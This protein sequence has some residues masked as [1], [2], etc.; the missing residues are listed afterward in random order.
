MP[1]AGRS[2]IGPSR[3]PADESFHL[4]IPVFTKC[5]EVLESGR[6]LENLSWRL[7]FREAHLMPPDMTLSDLAASPTPLSLDNSPM[8]TPLNRSR[9]GSFAALQQ[10][11]H[12]FAAQQQAQA[13]QSSGAAAAE[14]GLPQSFGA[15]SA[16]LASA[17]AASAAGTTPS[18]TP[19]ASLSAARSPHALGTSVR[20]R[21][22]ILQE[23][24]LENPESAESESSADE[25]DFVEEED[26]ER[27]EDENAAGPSKP[28]RRS[29]AASNSKR[30]SAP[31]PPTSSTPLSR[32]SSTRVSPS[33]S[34]RGTSHQDDANAPPSSYRQVPAGSSSA[35]AAVTGGTSP[36]RHRR[37]GASTLS[38]SSAFGS[39]ARVKQ[40]N[41]S[42]Y[43]MA[44]S[45]RN[46]GPGSLLSGNGSATSPSSSA[47]TA[48]TSYAAPNAAAMALALERKRRRPVSFQ[49]AVESMHLLSSPTVASSGDEGSSA[50]SAGSGAAHDAHGHATGAL[51]TREA[52]LRDLSMPIRLPQPRA[53]SLDAA[54][55]HA[56]NNGNGDAEVPAPT[57]GSSYD[58]TKAS[59][60]MAKARPQITTN[61][62]ADAVVQT[63][64]A[65]TSP[66]K[67][68]A[69]A[70]RLA[71]AA[72]P[73]QAI[74]VASSPARAGAISPEPSGY[75]T[76]TPSSPVEQPV[77]DKR[78]SKFFV[79]S[80]IS[81]DE[82]NVGKAAAGAQKEAKQEEEQEAKPAADHGKQKEKSH[83]ATEEHQ[84]KPSLRPA[85]SHGKTK[86]NSHTKAHRPHAHFA[87]TA[88]H[89]A[90][91]P[92][93]SKSHTALHRAGPNKLSHKGLAQLAHH[94]AAVPHRRE[95]ESVSTTSASS[96]V[97]DLSEAAA[98]QEKAAAQAQVPAV[99]EAEK[100]VEQAPAAEL[101]KAEEEMAKRRP[102]TF[103][104]GGDSDD[105]SQSSRS[106]SQRSAAGS[107]PKASA[108]QEQ[109]E[110]TA[111]DEN[112]A[113]G[114]DDDEW[115]SDESE[116]EVL[117]A[118]Q[119]ARLQRQKREEELFKK[120]P[121]RSKSAA[122]V[123]MLPSQQV[124]ATPGPSP[125]QQPVRGL[126]SS[127]FHPESEPHPP[128]GQ[129]A[130]R[131]HAS[132]ADLRRMPFSSLQMSR[133][134]APVQEQP[135]ARKEQRAPSTGSQDGERERT[136]AQLSRS[137]S[138]IRLAGLIGNDG[139]SGGG[140]GLR[141]SKSAVALP[142]LNMTASRSTTSMAQAASQ[143]EMGRS[144]RQ[145][146]ATAALAHSQRSDS[147]QSSS[148]ATEA[149]GSFSYASSQRSSRRDSAALARLSE[150]T[151]GHQQRAAA[152]RSASEAARSYPRTELALEPPTSA[153][154]LDDY[155]SLKLVTVPQPDADAED[156]DDTAGDKSGR[157]WNGTSTPGHTQSRS[158]DDA[159]SAAATPRQVEH[160]LSVPMAM[161]LPEG[162]APQTPRT[163]RRNMLRDELSESLRQN[164]LW[165]RQSR[166]RMLGIVG[167]PMQQA[168][169][170]AQQQQQHQ[171]AH[172]QHHPQQA[173][174]T[175]HSLR[176]DTVLGGG[177]IRPLTSARLPSAF[178]S[179]GQ[180]SREGSSQG[181]DSN[182]DGAQHGGVRRTKSEWGG[183]FHHTGW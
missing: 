85:L 53:R 176:K 136:A 20:S 138:G 13:Q 65:S 171:Q 84:N 45:T 74:D 25:N 137:R 151:S 170:A 158:A 71:V 6:R 16:A 180:M 33:H 9:A 41:Q 131:P 49:A 146:T 54:G 50:A 32:K 69:A 123:R 40:R 113:A 107:V 11:L 90:H 142:L 52:V 24:G 99:K 174:P 114:D 177:A 3:P 103:T 116:E 182:G 59:S 141:T 18:R 160:R 26:E 8:P 17:A 75:K 100:P 30:S 105:E 55:R 153:A 64:S 62:S 110:A 155:N 163:T 104:M 143:A 125:P 60:T 135:P 102:V 78:P 150:L 106:A 120:V 132:A 31:A 29:S 122:D 166:N 48:T 70:E 157:R 86:H 39:R 168:N 108:Q 81:D 145:P 36:S 14:N 101:K 178:A 96:S 127:I 139:G 66:V 89:H 67:V 175:A 111:G 118:A 172:E 133:P 94:A 58:E 51:S 7:W 144:S 5:A 63:A 10:S 15:A 28:R 77:G 21:E 148:G 87:H 34:R 181:A 179:T 134:P 129:L 93:R 164:L 91:L 23:E 35:A 68:E 38:S 98:K 4:F 169:A 167:G 140:A 156:G 37:S 124:D 42:L 73:T 61:R 1:T 159:G 72:Q 117:T 154:A 2:S 92:G 173:P 88:S 97:V 183:S 162:G 12:Q 112:A 22:A 115:S 57:G 19:F 27:E 149:S 121:I 165:E 130:G 46:A 56:E 128:P 147:G 47:S 83:A 161:D 126:L 109:K 76:V 82:D 43:A 95:T 119:L 80:Y 44:Q 79:A 152:N